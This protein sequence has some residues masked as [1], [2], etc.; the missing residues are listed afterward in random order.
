LMIRQNSVWVLNFS[1]WMSYRHITYRCP[2]DVS[3]STPDAENQ[4]E[5]MK[6]SDSWSTKGN[7]PMSQFWSDLPSAVYFH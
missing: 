6:W 2:L 3:W 7:S 5:H 1:I 4:S